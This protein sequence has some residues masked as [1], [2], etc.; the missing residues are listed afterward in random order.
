[1]AFLIGPLCVKAQTVTTGTVSDYSKKYLVLPGVIVR[2][3]NQ[4]TATVTTKDGKFTLG[5]KTGDVLEFSLL[6]YRPD[7]LFLTNLL[8]KQIY[9]AEQ[10][11]TLSD[12][13]VTGVKV[14]S[15]ILNVRDSTAEKPSL[16]GTGGNLQKKRMNDKVG[17]LSLNL[18]YGKY[19]REQIAT[20]KLEQREHFLDEIDRAFNQKTISEYIKLTPEEMK[21]F[22]VIYRP[23]VER[24]KADQPFN[25]TLYIAK[26][27]SAWNKLT[28]KQKKLADLPKLDGAG[29]SKEK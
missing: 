29:I 21:A 7:T 12:V 11:N 27:I 4:K 22:I 3:L 17:G 25:Y 16:L 1:M 6:G 10:S 28:P 23:S 14:N 8:K 15:S 24:V 13:N 26:A 18:G 2:N 19:R 5:A 9:L 20:Q